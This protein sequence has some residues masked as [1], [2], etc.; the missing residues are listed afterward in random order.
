M[1]IAEEYRRHAAE[2][3]ALASKAPTKEQREQIERIAETWR[4]LAAER[5]RW[6]RSQQNVPNKS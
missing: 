4:K 1:Q 6:L 3:E 5:E 2:C